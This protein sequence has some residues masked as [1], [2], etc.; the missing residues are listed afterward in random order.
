V[1]WAG[2]VVVGV[3]AVVVDCV[4]VVAG[5]CEALPIAASAAPP[6]ATSPAQ[7]VSASKNRVALIVT[8]FRLKGKQRAAGRGV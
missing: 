3:V 8:S 7:T 6:P 5:A 4:V 2:V 1:V